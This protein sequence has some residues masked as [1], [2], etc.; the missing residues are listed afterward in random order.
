MKK[1]LF[2]LLALMLVSTSCSNM[3]KPS[4]RE[5]VWSESADTISI[6]EVILSGD[7]VMVPFKRTESGLAEVQVSL[8]GVPFNMWWDTGASLTSISLLDLQNLIKQGKISVDDKIGSAI[9]SLADGSSS[10]EVVVNLKEIYIPGQD[11]KYLVLKDIAALV[12]KNIEAPLLIG[13][14]VITNLPKHS[15]NESNGVIEFD[16]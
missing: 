13:Q 1:I 16:K 5:S 2:L 14:N 8:N 12:S 3:Q 6:Q 11:N 10:E 4:K 7:K 9:V 15:F